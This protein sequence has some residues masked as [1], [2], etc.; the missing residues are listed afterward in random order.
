MILIEVWWILSYLNLLG[1]IPMELAL[2]RILSCIFASVRFWFLTVVVF[3]FITLIY[4]SENFSIEK[5]C[6]LINVCTCQIVSDPNLQVLSAAASK[7]QI[8]PATSD[9][10]I[11]INTIINFIK[12]TRK[13]ETE[14]YV[15]IKFKYILKFI[16][17]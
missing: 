13:Y 8:N 1:G 14:K 12:L 3:C 17:V 4:I 2:G 11:I 5:K 15:H 10:I 7:G 16:N 6:S 9:K